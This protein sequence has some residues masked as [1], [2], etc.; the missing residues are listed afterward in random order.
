MSHQFALTLKS[1]QGVSRAMPV[2]LS[3]CLAFLAGEFVSPGTQAAIVGALVA[4]AV[5]GLQALVTLRKHKIDAFQ[6]IDGARDKVEARTEGVHA[7]ETA[8]LQRQIEYHT[9][10]EV[11]ARNR[12]HSAMGEVQRCAAYI[13]LLQGLA[14]VGQVDVPAF[15]IKSY[16]EI[17]GP[18][19]LPMPPLAPGE[20]VTTLTQRKQQ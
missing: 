10:L 15:T 1:L 4:L 3:A 12:T 9:Q 16:N 19:E 2:I 13:S 20:T 18:E 8:F 11:I 5:A 6:A 17:I 7:A 14:R